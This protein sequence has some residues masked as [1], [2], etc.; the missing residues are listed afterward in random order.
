VTAPRPALREF[1]ETAFA[2]ARV[3]ALAGDASARS[4]YRIHT[5]DGTTRVVM[6]YGEPFAGEPDDVRAAKLFQAA[7]LPV[8]E[9][10]VAAGDPGCLIL[11]DPGDRRLEQALAAASADERRRLYDTA[12]E[13]SAA[14]ALNGTTELR[15]LGGEW[16]TLDAERFRFEMDFF[17]EHYARGL[18][19]ASPDAQL[20]GLLHD[21]AERAARTPCP[22][23]CHRDFHSRN[24]MVRADGSLVMVDIQ[25]ARW[26]PDTYDLASLLRDAYVDVDEGE[27]D[28]LVERYLGML[29]SAPDAGGFRRRFDVVAAQ[30]MIKALGT[31]GYQAARLG[32]TR[33]LE[34]VP[35]TLD[36]LRRWLPSRAETAPLG[37][38]L[39]EVRLLEPPAGASN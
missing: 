10:L 1:L 25:D 33:Y 39:A 7:G 22:V 34:G 30:R 37:E 12:V 13:L 8:A 18:R 14:I 17:V 20:V 26:G 11:E 28:R 5:A 4:F 38:A 32:R 23:L 27:V 35:R 2:G 21:L 15:R 29:T 36:R 19:E 31:F 24:L 3:E 6:D 9:I 16:A